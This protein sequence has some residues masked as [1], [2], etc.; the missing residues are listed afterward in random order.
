MLST[1]LRSMRTGFRP[2]QH[3]LLSLQRDSSL[4]M[5]RVGFTLAVFGFIMSMLLVGCSSNRSADID[6]GLKAKVWPDPAVQTAP[7]S[8]TSR[9]SE[10][11][12]PVN[13]EGG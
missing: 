6:L 10:P 7:A 13:G 12:P 8:S 4:Y 11:L 1:L 3:Q 2:M 9:K 5:Y